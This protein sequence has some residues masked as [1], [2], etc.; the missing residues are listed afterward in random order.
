MPIRYELAQLLRPH[1]GTRLAGRLSANRQEGPEPTSHLLPRQRVAQMV[2]AVAVAVAAGISKRVSPKLLRHKVATRLPALAM[3]ITYLQRFLGHGVIATIRLYA[4]TTAATLQ[5]RS[6]QLTDHTAH[7]LM[8]GSRES[9]AD[10]GVFLAAE[11]LNQRRAE[12]VITA[13]T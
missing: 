2:R 4:E 6:E 7:T 12:R 8:A 9:Q 11:L 10:R 3:D 13:D 1:I 5:R